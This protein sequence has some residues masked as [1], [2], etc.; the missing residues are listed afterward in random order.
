LPCSADVADTRLEVVLRNGRMLRVPEGVTPSHVR[1]LADA[2][3]GIG[4]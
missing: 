4:Q 2:L 1:A 3:E